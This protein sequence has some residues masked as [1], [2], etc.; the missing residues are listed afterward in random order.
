VAVELHGRLVRDS[1]RASLVTAAGLILMVGVL[2]RSLRV[3]LLVLLPVAYGILVT[4]GVL[5]LAGHHFGG[6]GF[7]AFP[8]IAG[9]GIDNGIHLVRRHLEMEEKDVRRLLASSGAALIQTNLT[10]IVGFGALLSATIPPL[11][12][13]GLITAVGIVFTLLASVF[14]VPAVLALS[15]P[16]PRAG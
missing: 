14:L 16:A 13:L 7:A 15:P 9:L 5:T 1:R 10:T 11:A 2:F 6:M 8:L 3:G 4:V 12:E